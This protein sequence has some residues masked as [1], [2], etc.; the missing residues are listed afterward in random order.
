MVQQKIEND[1]IISP[2]KE[3]EILV[4]H[5]DLPIITSLQGKTDYVNKQR[6]VGSFLWERKFRTL[7][8]FTGIASGAVTSVMLSVNNGYD[9]FHGFLPPLAMALAGVSWGNLRSKFNTLIRNAQPISLIASSVGVAVGATALYMANGHLYDNPLSYFGLLNAPRVSALMNLAGGYIFGK[10]LT[11]FYLGKKLNKDL[12]NYDSFSSEKGRNVAQQDL[13]FF[14]LF[15]E[16]KTAHY[17]Y[18]ESDAERKERLELAEA[19]AASELK[20][21]E[22]LERI[23]KKMAEGVIN[24]GADSEVSGMS[25]N[26]KG[27]EQTQSNTKEEMLEYM[28]SLKKEIQSGETSKEDLVEKMKKLQEMKNNMTSQNDQKSKVKPR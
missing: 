5:K 25:P 1:E 27:K 2:V 7:A 23:S 11:S 17:Q 14:K 12:S 21:R 9:G 19:Q 18:K 8:A 24:D 6:D 3:Q 26:V 28:E 4:K 20:E 13:M 15:I 10:S 16:G 22:K